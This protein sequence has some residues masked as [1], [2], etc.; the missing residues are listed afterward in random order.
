MGSIEDA[1]V[2]KTIVSSQIEEIRG[3]LKN[4]QLLDASSPGFTESL[5]RWSLA[6]IKPAVSFNNSHFYDPTSCF[7]YMSIA[8]SF[9]TAANRQIWT[10]LMLLSLGSRPSCRVRGRCLQDDRLLQQT[11]S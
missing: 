8:Q 3:Q 6:A 7:F 1:E 11:Q 4:S 5:V 9:H 10:E 2:T